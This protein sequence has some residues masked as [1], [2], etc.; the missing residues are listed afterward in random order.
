MISVL[1]FKPLTHF[2]LHI[3][4]ILQP[5]A[6]HIKGFV[7]IISFALSEGCTLAKLTRVVLNLKNYLLGNFTA[8]NLLC[9]NNIYNQ[10]TVLKKAACI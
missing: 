3:K 9:F 7:E 2:R 6:T 8:E 10:N 1:Y 4:R 5:P